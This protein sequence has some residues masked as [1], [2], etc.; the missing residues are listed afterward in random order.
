VPR[1]CSDVS[2]VRLPQPFCLGWD[3]TKAWKVALLRSNNE[4]HTPYILLEHQTFY[5]ISCNTKALQRVTCLDLSLACSGLS[6]RA[7]SF[8]LIFSCQRGM[9]CDAPKVLVLM[10]VA[11]ALSADLRSG[12]ISSELSRMIELSLLS[13]L[14]LAV[15]GFWAIV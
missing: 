14:F 3:G 10:F 9:D 6:P 13:D 1:C 2:L 7:T 11:Q 4:S 12:S 5:L 8:V 15:E